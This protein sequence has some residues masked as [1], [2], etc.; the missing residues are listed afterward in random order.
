M[1]V[2]GGIFTKGELEVNAYRGKLSLPENA[3]PANV[4]E[5]EASRLRMAYD[6]T[7]L[8]NPTA[9]LPLNR[10]VE[11]YVETPKRIQP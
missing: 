10:A 1:N 9:L 8:N 4:T 5:L 3:F 2:R 11:L 6:A 7:V